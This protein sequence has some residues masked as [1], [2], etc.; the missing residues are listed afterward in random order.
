MAQAKGPSMR[1]SAT[2][3]PEGPKNAGTPTRNHPAHP[4]GSGH[5]HASGPAQSQHPGGTGRGGASPEKGPQ[6][7][8]PAEHVATDA[9]PSQHTPQSTKGRHSTPAHN[10]LHRMGNRHAHDGRQERNKRD[11][12]R[13]SPDPQP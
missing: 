13:R 4:M 3:G 9:A 5:G 8:D 12:R 2:T 11:T 1:Y 10:G 7:L 6:R